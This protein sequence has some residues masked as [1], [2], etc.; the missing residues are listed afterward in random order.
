MELQDGRQAVGPAVQPDSPTMAIRSPPAW[1]SSAWFVR[2]QADGGAGIEPEHDVPE[3]VGLHVV[4][5]L[6]PRGEPLR[7]I[8][9]PVRC[10]AAVTRCTGGSPPRTRRACI[11]GTW[12]AGCS[13][14]GPPRRCR[15][16]VV[17][18]ESDQ[19]GFPARS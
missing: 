2:A 8:V 14:A 15:Y 11:Q 13:T 19:T 1:R 3:P 5:K 18:I 12:L 9:P 10:G 6:P 7:G 4:E 16:I 17:Q